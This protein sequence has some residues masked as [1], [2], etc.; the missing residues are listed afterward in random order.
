[1]IGGFDGESNVVIAVLLVVIILILLWYNRDQI[2]G[3]DKDK[4]GC[5]GTAGYTWDESLQKCV[6]PWE[7]SATA[8]TGGTKDSHGCYPAAGYVWSDKFQKCVHPWD[9]K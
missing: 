1:M 6:R 4:H 5:V 7:E 9:G 8:P 3:G 2:F